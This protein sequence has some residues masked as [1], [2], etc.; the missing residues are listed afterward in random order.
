MI[1][2]GRRGPVEAG[3]RDSNSRAGVV[4]NGCIPVPKFWNEQPNVVR[5]A[6]ASMLKPR[7]GRIGI[8]ETGCQATNHW[9]RGVYDNF[10]FIHSSHATFLD[11]SDDALP[12]VRGPT[13][14]RLVSAPRT[15]RRRRPIMY[16]LQPRSFLS[17][18]LSLE[19]L[20]PQFAAPPPSLPV[21]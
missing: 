15:L 5:N 2:E 3:R 1:F 6:A 17:Q 12:P 7:T 20:P 11:H 13:R 21:T 14:R 16:I 8:R 18:S 19:D 9:F 10:L 4:A